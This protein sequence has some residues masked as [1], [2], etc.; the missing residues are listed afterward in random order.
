MEIKNLKKY[1]AEIG[2]GET[3]NISLY[4]EAFTH[5]S[6]LNEKKGEN[7]GNHNERLEFLGDAVL[8][9][10][11]SEHLFKTYANR[12][13]GELTSFRAATV[14]TETLAR[15]ARDLKYGEYLRM[16]IGEE[17]TGGREKDYL[18]ANT[19]EAVLGALYLDKGFE[20]CREFVHQVLIPIINE[21]VENRL[22]I[23]PKTKFQEL[24]QEQYKVTPI[25]KVVAEEGPD[26][27]KIFTMAV[28]VNDKEMGRGSG[29][30]KQK[31]EEQAASEA[32][33]Q[34]A[35]NNDKA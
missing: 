9:L 30:S 27:N 29:S 16:S 28:L 22:D 15:I 19:F 17:N 8:E 24:A 5:R 18:L 14:R 11:V 6:Y 1:L 26:H 25:Y 13:E 33:Q 21:I 10:I 4:E 2:I 20:T 31:A 12:P 7:V 3:S 32:L 34:I 35:I 23:D